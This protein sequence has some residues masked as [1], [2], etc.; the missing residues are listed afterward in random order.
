[1]GRRTEEEKPEETTIEEPV[2]K[3]A[4]AGEALYTVRN[5]ANSPHEVIV[6]QQTIRWDARGINPMF[7]AEYKDGV[8]ERII[9]HKHFAPQKKYFQIVKIDKR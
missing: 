9:N 6:K 4:P 3:K 1:M 7:P 2:G 8:P 5:L